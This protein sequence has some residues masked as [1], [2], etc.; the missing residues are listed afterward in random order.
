MTAA[1]EKLLLK[2]TR[3]PK[4]PWITPE[5]TEQLSTAKAKKAREDPDHS[6]SYKPLKNQARQVKPVG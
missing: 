1:E 5:L 4:Q 3:E 2:V 6:A